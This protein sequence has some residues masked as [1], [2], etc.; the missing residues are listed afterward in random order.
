MQTKYYLKQN[1]KQK[2]KTI[3]KINGPTKYRD[4]IY[5]YPVATAHFTK[6]KKGTHA[7]AQIERKRECKTERKSGRKASN[8]KNNIMKNVLLWSFATCATWSNSILI[9][10]FNTIIYGGTRQRNRRETKYKNELDV[11][12]NGVLLI[13]VCVPKEKLRC[14]SAFLC[15]NFSVL[16]L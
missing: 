1:D 4:T 13:I 8:R 7:R 6:N 5:D 16:P 11:I 14:F 3:C 10:C 2:K 12:W 15:L 9:N